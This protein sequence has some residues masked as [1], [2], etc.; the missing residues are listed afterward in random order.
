MHIGCDH[1]PWLFAHDE[2]DRLELSFERIFELH[3]ASH[4]KTWHETEDTI[5]GEY[6]AAEEAAEA[7]I[8][9]ILSEVVGLGGKQESVH[10]SPSVRE[11]DST[12]KELLSSA[13]PTD[14]LCVR[15]FRVCAPLRAWAEERYL[16]S[17]KHP[18]VFRLWVNAHLLPAK[19]AFAETGSNE[20][21]DETP[22]MVTAV[23]W[24]LAALYA[25]RIRHALGVL[26]S[27][28]ELPFGSAFSARA[29]DDINQ[30][31]VARQTLY[32]QKARLR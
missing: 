11:A 30:S 26:R 13:V 8:Q 16:H 6:I 7:K 14:P 3:E 19:V 27:R 20:Q 22:P 31:L 1:N 25:H 12:L 21:G 17:K 2:L 23:E 5:L 9:L 18:A 15:V 4:G 29:F 24:S 28:G 32:E 10:T